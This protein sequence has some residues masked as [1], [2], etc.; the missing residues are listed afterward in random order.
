ME[1]ISSTTGS[2]ISVLD[3]SISSESSNLIS[4]KLFSLALLPA[5]ILAA[6]PP[7]TAAPPTAALSNLEVLVVALP[8]AVSV[9]A[10][11]VDKL[12]PSGTLDIPP[13]PGGLILGGTSP[14]A[15]SRSLLFLPPKPATA[16]AA[17]IGI[18]SI[19]GSHH[20]HLPFFSVATASLS[21]SVLA[22][23]AIAPS[24][25][26]SITALGSPLPSKS[27]L[28]SPAPSRFGFT[29]PAPSKSGLS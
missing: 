10:P 20:H 21:T 4:S 23:G 22:S 25:S 8:I 9:L 17:K 26:A 13:S 24:S 18:P 15:G 14:I 27:G 7:A 28:V 3:S 12:L 29:S 6:V 11:T 1:G 2:S 5:T 19:K 16:I